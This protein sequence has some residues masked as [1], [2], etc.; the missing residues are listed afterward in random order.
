MHNAFECM[1][2]RFH[3]AALTQVFKIDDL[4]TTAIEQGVLNGLRQ[5][6]E[7]QIEIELVVRGQT[8][9]HDEIELIAPIPTFDR[10]RAER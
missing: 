7:W 4:F 2:A 1:R 10:A 5:R 3:A 6:F 8:L 9:Q